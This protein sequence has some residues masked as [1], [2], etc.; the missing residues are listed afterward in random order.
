MNLG[1]GGTNALII[2]TY[3]GS[4]SCKGRW[5]ALMRPYRRSTELATETQW[6]RAAA[7]HRDLDLGRSCLNAGNHPARKNAGNRRGRGT[8]E[9][10]GE[11]ERDSPNFFS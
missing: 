7:G 5:S 9:E 8:G 11:G 2:C 6:Q 1:I 10:E 3:L 4:L